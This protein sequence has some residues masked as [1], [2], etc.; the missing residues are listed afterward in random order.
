LWAPAQRVPDNWL[1][2]IGYWQ[3]EKNEIGH[4]IANYKISGYCK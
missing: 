3:G 2:I 4:K 1:M